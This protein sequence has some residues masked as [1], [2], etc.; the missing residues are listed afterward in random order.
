MISETG[1][2]E[3]KPYTKK[4]LAALY[5]MPVKAFESL[6]RQYEDQ[7]GKKR[8]WYYTVHQVETIVK[9]IGFRR[10]LHTD[11]KNAKDFY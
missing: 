4:E 3:L 10:T 8:G 9:C 7:I 2:F 11:N 5:D 6:L 1:R